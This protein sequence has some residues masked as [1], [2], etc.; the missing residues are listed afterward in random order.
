LRPQPAYA[1]CADIIHYTSDERALQGSQAGKFLQRV[2]RRRFGGR[3]DGRFG[4]VSADVCINIHF[5]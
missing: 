5:H 3:S 4:D 2:D 1:G